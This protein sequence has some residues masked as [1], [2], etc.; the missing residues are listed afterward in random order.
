M[1]DWPPLPRSG[2]Y[3]HYKGCLFQVLFCAKDSTNSTLGRTMVVYIGLTLDGASP[4]LRPRVRELSE[5]VG[6]VTWPDGV[7]RSRFEYVGEEW[8]SE[9]ADVR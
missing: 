4:G 8:R 3:R 5:F 2:V 7:T 9:V 1:P 6:A